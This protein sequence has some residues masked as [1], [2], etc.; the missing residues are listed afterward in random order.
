MVLRADSGIFITNTFGTAPLVAD[1]LI[2]TIT[3]AYLSTSGDWTNASDKSLKSNFKHV[4]GGELLRALASLPISRWNYSND[5]SQADHIGPTAQDFYAA[6]GLGRDEKTISTV[7]PSGIALAAIKELHNTQ[8]Q[9]LSKS[10]RVERLES[11]VESLS[12]QLAE[13]RSLVL[14]N[15]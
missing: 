11:Q 2:N 8:Q 7:D 3:G 13:L 14:Q 1:R 6:F 5:D 4:D 9:L 15:K 10:D 12:Q